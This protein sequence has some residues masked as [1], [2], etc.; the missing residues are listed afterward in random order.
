LDKK[1][2]SFP[3]IGSPRVADNP[4]VNSVFITPTNDDYGVIGRLPVTV[5]VV[6][7]SIPARQFNMFLIQYIEIRLQDIWI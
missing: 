3:P 1:I 4:V 7:N 5:S 2:T 6:V